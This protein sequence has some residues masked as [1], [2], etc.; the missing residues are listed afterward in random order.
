MSVEV[1]ILNFQQFVNRRL[2]EINKQLQVEE[3]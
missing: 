3:E 2:R 1:K